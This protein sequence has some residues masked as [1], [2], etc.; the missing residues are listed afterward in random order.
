MVNME[1]NRD[2]LPVKG[3]Y[4]LWNAG[5]APVVPFLPI[6]A[7][8]LGFSSVV[9]GTIYTVLPITG[10]LAK[11]IFGAVADHFQLQKTLFLAFQIL[12]AITFFGIQFIPEIQM[13]NLNQVTLDCDG[14]VFFKTCSDDMDKCAEARVIAESSGNDTVLCELS[15]VADPW[16]T[17]EVCELWKADVYCNL[18]G[19]NYLTFGATV[20]LKSTLRFDPCLHFRIKEV[21]V[22]HSEHIPYCKNL[23]TSQC[24]IQCNDHAI[25]EVLRKPSVTDSNVADFYQFW[26]FFLLMVLSWISMAV[27]VSIGDAICF[28]MLGDQPSRYG[29]QRLWGA[30]GW[31]IFAVIAGVL[32]DEMSKG[33]SQEDY[34][35]VFYMMLV[36]LLLDVFVSS[37]IKHSQTKLSTSIVRDV[38]K[39]LTEVRIVVFMLWCI[40]VGL[41][42]GLQWNFLFWHL[43]DMATAEGCDMVHWMK[44]IEGLV[45]GVQCFGGELPFLFLSGRILRKIGHV[46]TM[47]LILFAFGLRFIIYSVLKDPWWCL[48]VELFQGFTFGLF[49]ATMA[50]YASIVAPP[51]TEATV[52]GTVGAVFEGVGVS[53]GSLLGGILYDKFGGAKTFR[54]YGTASLALFIIHALVQLL[55]GRKSH[56]S[57]KARDFGT[58]AHYA[59][60][61]EALN[62]MDDMQELTP[63]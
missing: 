55:L 49:Y 39:L 47:S 35:I 63:S 43:E 24:S 33:K 51:G 50:S 59:A 31:G 28:E 58:S 5:T 21:F 2:L 3:Q 46:H 22:D 60:P 37:K 44:T 12:T 41:C 16:L 18:T 36:M 7:R 34:T 19:S 6:Y 56:Y 45:M 48:P 4:F 27:V 10:M 13:E 11:P 53:L 14:T 26:L 29:H 20:P 54:I 62:M 42:T 57:E 9:V 30:V 1:V 38:G 17:K 32:V 40:A 15:C 25:T 8:Q 61:N 52:Q 23:T